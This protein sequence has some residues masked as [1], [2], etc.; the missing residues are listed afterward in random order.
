MSVKSLYLRILSRHLIQLLSLWGAMHLLTYALTHSV[1]DFKER[2]G[3]E[4]IEGEPLVFAGYISLA[5]SLS[6]LTR[7]RYW[8]TLGLLGYRTWPL[9]T[10]LWMTS[11]GSTLMPGEQVNTTQRVEG[12]LSFG[13]GHTQQVIYWSRG[14]AS[15]VSGGQ[16]ERW[17]EFPPPQHWPTAEAAHS[18]LRPLVRG[19]I[20]M[21]LSLFILKADVTS[22][23]ERGLGSAILLY[24]FERMISAALIWL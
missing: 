11:F 16:L 20:L 2:I 21:L 17:R 10:L 14:G 7:L 6:Q 24:F 13:Q 5:W 3:G 19:V 4:V 8:L 1:A 12:A 23:K 18:A 22:I 9:L 15:R